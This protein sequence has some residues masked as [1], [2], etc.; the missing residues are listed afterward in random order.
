MN[1]RKSLV[2]VACVCAASLPSL[3]LAASPWHPT[4]DDAGVS[5]HP[6]HL[7]SPKTRSQVIAELGAARKD[8]SM[9]RNQRELDSPQSPPTEVL[10][11]KSRQQVTDELRQQ[12]PMERRTRFEDL[13]GG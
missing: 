8:G 6:D 13:A 10:P 9:Y 12:S 1:V 11:A 4:H 2:L 7:N 5:F 3:A